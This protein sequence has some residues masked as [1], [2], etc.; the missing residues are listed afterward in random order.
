M[1]KFSS[2]SF[3]LVA[4]LLIFTSCDKDDDGAPALD[5]KLLEGVWTANKQDWTM[6]VLGQSETETVDVKISVEF[7]A[8]KTYTMDDEGYEEGGTYSLSGNTLTMDSGDEK[9]EHQVKEL[10]AGKLTV[11]TVDEST[12]FKITTTTFFTK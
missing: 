11:Y 4:A 8:D 2:L 3:M 5:A 1:K 9:T 7:K 6:E 10:S 12:G